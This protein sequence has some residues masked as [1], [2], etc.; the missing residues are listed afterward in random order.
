[1]II[2]FTQ[3]T[4]SS[5]N[6]VFRFEHLPSNKKDIL[7]RL[8]NA[9]IS[10]YE[11]DPIKKEIIESNCSCPDFN[12]NRSGESDCKHMTESKYWL[13]QILK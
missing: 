9:W 12:L 2:P 3:H 4:N 1:M 5:G 7:D 10:T 11:F 8:E 13:N 6:I